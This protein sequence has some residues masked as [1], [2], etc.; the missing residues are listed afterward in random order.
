MSYCDFMFKVL[1]LGEPSSGKYWLTQTYLANYLNT[2]KMRLSIGINFYLKCMNLNGLQI[3]LQIWDVDT[4]CNFSSLIPLYCRG[5]KAALILYDITDTSIFDNLSEWVNLIKHNAG[6]IPILLVGCKLE[7]EQFR[8]VSHEDA[9]MLV[10]KFNLRG[11]I[12][13]SSR[14]GQNVDD[15][16]NLFTNMIMEKYSPEVMRK[17]FLEF[18][19]ND[20]LTLRLLHNRT[21]IYVKGML[22]NQCK[23]LLLNLRKDQ[24]ESY[25]DIESIDEAAETLDR[26]LETTKSDN[27]ISPEAEFWG[28]CSNLQAWYENDY[29]TRLLHRNLAFPLLKALTDA[30]D[31]LAKKVFKEEIAMR[32]ESGYPTVVRYLVDQG[33]LQYLTNEEL[34]VVLKNSN[35]VVNLSHWCP[36]F[37]N[38]PDKLIYMIKRKSNQIKISVF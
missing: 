23:Y 21:N 32:L 13:I 28:H 10:K 30:G 14:T 12:E 36:R 26:S 35:F 27:D 15:M 4:H 2:D 17:S 11:F 31:P 38:L 3:R 25:D 29:D 19:I 9:L 18:K 37:K 16:F 7:L 22:F 1:L 34:N 24:F 8:Q 6:N 20:Y 5:S 33:Y